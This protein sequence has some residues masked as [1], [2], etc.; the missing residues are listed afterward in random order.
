MTETMR[1]IVKTKPTPGLALETV[2]I[3]E[4]GP[5]DVLIRVRRTAICGTD[6]HIDDWNQ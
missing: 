2:P 5:D 3:P 6:V 1:A 4:P